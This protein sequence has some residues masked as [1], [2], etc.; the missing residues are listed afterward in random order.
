[1]RILIVSVT[2]GYGHHS[3]AKAIAEE[4]QSRNIDVIVEDLYKCT[5]T[6]LYDLVDHGYLFSTKYIPRQFGSAYSYLEG[7]EKFSRFLSFVSEDSRIARKFAEYIRSYDPDLI[8]STHIF[9][10]QVL[11]ELKRRSL[12]TVPVIGII[13]DYCIHP[14]WESCTHCDYTVTASELLTYIANKRGIPTEKILPYGIPVSKKFNTCISK[15]DA[16]AELGL[17]D[18]LYTILVMFGSMGY[19]KVLPIIAKL[20]ELDIPMQIVCICGNNKTLYRNLHL[21]NVNVPLTICGFIDN[22]D[23]YM[24]ASD[25]IITKPGGL[26]VS[27]AMAKKLPMILINPIPGQEERNSDFLVN[28]GVALRVNKHF[29]ISEALYYLFSNPD[30][31]PLMQKTIELIAHPDASKKLCDFIVELINYKK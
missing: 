2:A 20:A 1:M 8:V 27:E 24:D 25:C 21:L 30:R 23:L 9:A 15:S 11:D 12:I 28:N 14:F 7:N 3:T 10:A 31:L 4:L 18:D 19:G 5:S 17:R 13:T 26:T 22:V 16:R 29:S 6:F